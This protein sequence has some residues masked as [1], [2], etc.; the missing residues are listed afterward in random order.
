MLLRALVMVALVAANA[1][2]VSPCPWVTVCSSV[3]SALE[4]EVAPCIWAWIV[5]LAV[6]R[7]AL[8]ALSASTLPRSPCAMV[9]TA[10]LLAAELTARPDWMAD[11]VAVIWLLIWSSDWIAAMALMLV[12]TDVTITGVSVYCG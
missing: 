9:K 2:P 5:A 6:E 10:G 1:A 8:T 11:C 4:I 3:F 12:L 7:L